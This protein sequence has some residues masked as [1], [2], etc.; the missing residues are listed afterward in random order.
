MIFLT[1]YKNH[2]S[3]AQVGAEVAELMYAHLKPIHNERLQLR[4]S[5]GCS[6]FH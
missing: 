6:D 3:S 4:F 5:V 1:H 2:Q